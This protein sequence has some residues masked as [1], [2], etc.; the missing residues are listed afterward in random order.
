[1]SESLKDGTKISGFVRNSENKGPRQ[2]SNCC[3]MSKGLCHH[4][5]VMLD[6]EV[7][8]NDEG[9]AKVDGDDCCDSFQSQKNALIYIVRHGQT[10]SNQENKF[11][12]WV[13]ID[14]DEVGEKQAKQA[15]QFLKG[16]KIKHAYTSDLS[17][18]AETAKAFDLKTT[19]DENLRPWDIGIFANKPREIYQETLNRYIDEP[20]K[21]IP[22]GE[23]LSQFAER[24]RY[25]L[26]KY[27]KVA[28]ESG[29]ILLVCHSS[30]CIQ[31][32]KQVE[33][34][35]ELGRPEDVVLIAPGGIFLIL[36]EDG[37][38]KAEEL[39]RREGK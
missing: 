6:P 16:R 7:H 21:E 36:D 1:M 5:L 29:P 19:R 35:D 33:G 26:D 34:K 28:R 12:G 37:K 31:I 3:W 27:V 23:S 2:C 38:L 13:N 10:K 20:D 22:K 30:N 17:R 25:V 4:P 32:E 8:H 39:W 15:A 9:F 14:L 11:R 24:M 18:A